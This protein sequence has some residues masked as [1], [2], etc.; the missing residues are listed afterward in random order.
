M[1]P[2]PMG[3]GL[4]G[5]GDGWLIFCRRNF[6]GVELYGDI[7]IGGNCKNSCTKFLLCVLISLCRLNY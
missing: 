1:P 3:I 2:K 4:F 6:P 7:Y 5:F